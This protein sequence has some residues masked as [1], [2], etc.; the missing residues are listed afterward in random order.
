MIRKIVFGKWVYALGVITAIG[1][2]GMYACDQSDI[3]EDSPVLQGVFVDSRVVGLQYQTETEIGITGPNGEFNYRSGETITFFIGDIVLGEAEAE[4]IMTPVDLVEGATDQMDDEVTNIARLLQTLDDDGDPDNGILI[5]QAVR[6]VAVGIT[7]DFNVTIDEFEDN[8]DVQDAVEDLTE[9]R[10]AGVRLLAL[11]YRVQVHLALT[12]ADPSAEEPDEEEPECVETPQDGT[13]TGTTDQGYS[14]SFTLSNGQVTNIATKMDYDDYNS[15]NC[16]G[17]NALDTGD[18]AVPLND[19]SFSFSTDQVEIVGNFVDATTVSGT[20]FYQNA[21]C[22]GAG[23]GIWSASTSGET[24]P[25]E[26]ADGDG[27]S[28]DY[29]CD[30]TDPTIFVGAIEV[31][32][33]GIDQ[34]CDGSDL[35][36][37]DDDDNSSKKDDDDD[38]SKKDD[39]SSKKDDDSSKKDDD[40]SKKD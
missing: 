13:Y 9:V 36:C 20:W 16:V 22:G 27:Y 5:T 3:A 28:G 6:E 37:T 23:N 17:T 19:C 34:D 4:P 8:P 26:D 12:L 11:V 18:I 35:I 31:C 14:F 7:L 39:D 30:E 10:T 2:L 32:G 15:E 38:S 24:D 21:V 40:S 1:M 25:E 33:D 29:D